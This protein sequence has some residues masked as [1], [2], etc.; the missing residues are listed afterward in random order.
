M[1]G[2]L[3]LVA[4]ASAGAILASMLA[5]WLVSI[6][7]KDASIVD[8][9]WGP[10]FAVGAWV[11]VSLAGG[12]PARKWLVA[13]LTTIWALRLGLYLFRRKRGHGEDSRH[14]ALINHLGPEK[15]HW[16]ALTRVF[17]LQGAVM[18]VV[19]LPVM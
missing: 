8:I 5:L 4:A 10:G 11:S 2:E 15:R 16:T 13:I 3:A 7:L 9:F 1:W 18:W 14:T 6:P 19:A 12:V 17:L